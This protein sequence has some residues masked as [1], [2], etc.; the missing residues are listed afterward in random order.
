MFTG[1]IAATGSIQAIE[2][3]G[4]DRRF[5]VNSGKLD[6]GDVKIGDSISVN[7]TCLTVV[8]LLD[9]AFRTDLSTETLAVTTFATAVEGSRV[10]LEKALMLSDRLGGHIVSGH[11]DGIGVI[12]D[13][14][15]DARSIRYEIGI[16][17]ALNRYLCKKG[18]ICIDGVSLTVN[19]VATNVFYVNIIPHTMDETIFPGYG[20]DTQVNLEV[21]LIARYLEGLQR[22][23]KQV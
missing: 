6:L 3:R 19:D 15:E 22:E 7:G 1:I 10:N 2:D 18:S 11:V 16:P 13:F 23:K 20:K 17:A 9:G 5:T 8:E 12:C 14:H 21:D 4:A